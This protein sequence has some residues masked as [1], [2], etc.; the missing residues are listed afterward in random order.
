MGHLAC[1]QHSGKAISGVRICTCIWLALGV[2]DGGGMALGCLCQT[3]VMASPGDLV[4]GLG[5]TLEDA[6]SSNS[7]VFPIAGASRVVAG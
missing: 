5:L 7:W 1:S 3:R 2:M 4:V 6:R